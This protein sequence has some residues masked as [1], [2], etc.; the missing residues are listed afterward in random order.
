MEGNQPVYTYQLEEGI[1]AD[2]HGMIII[3]NEGILEMLRAGASGAR[4]RI[5]GAGNYA[6][7]VIRAWGTRTGIAAVEWR[8][9]AGAAD[10]RLISRRWRI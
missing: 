4:T 2:R 7:C 9:R 1:T 10:L 5:K 8:A 6:F 3:N